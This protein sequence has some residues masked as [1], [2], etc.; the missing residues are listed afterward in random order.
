MMTDAPLS[1]VPRRALSDE[2]ADLIR[3]AIL[4]G[5]YEP[6]GALREVE[7]AALLDISRG[8]V[9]EGLAILE[10]EG[11]ILRAWHRGTRVIDV[12]AED[13]MEVYAVRAALD[14]LAAMTAH[15]QASSGDFLALTTIVDQMAD[16]VSGRAT[17]GELVRLD[18][19]FHDRIYETANNRRLSSAWRAIRSQIHLFQL[20]RVERGDEDYRAR[21][22]TEH[23]TFIEL[24]EH[25]TRDQIGRDAEEHVLAARESLLRA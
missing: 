7:L 14:R 12:A 20:R 1:A 23:R 25:G 21:I 22:V 18:I 10:A 19:Q 3:E 16:A 6:G 5:R 11:L 13:V 15:A 2:A 8:S 9:R 4:G 17:G 24:L